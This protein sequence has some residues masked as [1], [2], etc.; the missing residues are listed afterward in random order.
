M[1]TNKFTNL[2][3]AATLVS[4]LSACSSIGD[5]NGPISLEL[6]IGGAGEDAEVFACQVS[7]PSVEVTFTNGTIGNFFN[8]GRAITYSS[9]DPEVLAV[10]DGSFPSPDG[11]FFVPG[12]LVPIKPGTAT[13][14]VE[15]LTFSDS[16]DV[17]VSPSVID[18]TPKTQTLVQGQSVFFSATAVLQGRDSLTA[19]DYSNLGQW[20][21]VGAAEETSASTIEAGNGLLTAKDG[22]EGTDTV[23]FSI[24]FCDTTNSVQV[25]VVNQNLESVRLVSAD[26]PDVALDAVNLPPDASFGVRAIGT[27]SGGFEQDLTNRVSFS[28]SGE[29]VGFANLRGTG[30]LTSLLDA[31]GQSSTVSATFD[32]D[33]S[34]EGDEIVS[35]EIP[36]NVL[37]LSL[38][39]AS[40]DITPKDALMLQNSTLQYSVSGTFQGNGES[41][42]WDLS[43]DVLWSSDEPSLAALLN[44]SGS[45]GL[46]VASPSQVG[47]TLVAAQRV[48]GDGGEEFPQ[49]SLTVGAA[50]EEADVAQIQALRIQGEDE[51]LVAGA[52][53]RFKAIADIGPLDQT[54]ASQEISSGV[55]WFS[56][57]ASLASVS[58]AAISR[59]VLTVLTDQADQMITL[60]AKV[61]DSSRQEQEFTATVDLVLNP[62]P[63]EEAQEQAEAQP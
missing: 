54:V 33:S 26:Q 12:V 17:T 20:R 50:D 34:V 15:Y 52:S 3:V 40:L 4:T 62:S 35:A 63:A 59:G 8:Q 58:N 16:I 2:C 30:L 60:T 10:S 43:Q 31:Q 56:S 49:V 21:V 32:P 44:T 13:I 23:E 45:R 37:D 24:D 51:A 61:F 11:Q 18:I 29:D 5:G 7:S 47:T 28:F 1:K 19:V 55:V 57:D 14:T 6:K 39:P 36:F 53:V 48:S 9:S 38:D 22:A 25:T 46:A 42:N 27:F 41:V